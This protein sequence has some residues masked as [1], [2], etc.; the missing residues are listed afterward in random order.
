MGR[1]DGKVAF[2]TGAARGQG[3]AHAVRFAQEG[4]KIIAIDVCDSLPTV[5]YPMPAKD[6]LDETARLVEAAGGEILT[7]VADVRDQAALDKA[8]TDGVSAFGG[9]DILVANAGILNSEGNAWEIS[10]RAWQELIDVNLTGVWRTIKAV[11]PRMLDT[12]RGGSLVLTSSYT[13]LK[14]EPQIAHYAAAKHGVMGLTRSLAHEL[15]PH[16]IRVNSVNPGNTETGMVTNDFSFGLLRPDLEKP[17]RDDAAATLRQLTLLD[18]DFIQPEDIAN[19][20][21]WLA[22]DEARYVT[23]IAIPVDAGWYAKST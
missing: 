23:G 19:A 6:D 1:L 2:I 13:G 20:A 3:R 16:N 4:A 11:V 12:G 5:P 18:V 22:S 14:G 15:G 8:A 10:D 17:G 21:L 7:A 9:I